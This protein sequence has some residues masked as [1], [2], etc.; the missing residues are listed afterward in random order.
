MVFGPSLGYLC[1]FQSVFFT[2]CLSF[3]YSFTSPP[4]AACCFFLFLLW[5]SSLDS[6]SPPK[7]FHRAGISYEVGFFLGGRGFPLSIS[8]CESLASCIDSLLPPLPITTRVFVSFSGYVLGM[9]MV[10]VCSLVCICEHQRSISGIFSL[11]LSTFL[12]QARSLTEARAYCFLHRLPGLCEWWLA[13]CVLGRLGVLYFSILTQTFSS[14]TFSFLI[15]HLWVMTPT[16]VTYQI[17]YKS[18]I[19]MTVPDSSEIT[20]T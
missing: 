7:S 6:A 1:D 12:Y 10:G 8:I 18:D 19:R 9:C 14:Q 4:N 13:G 15:L 3:I 11:L 20:V 2:F 5:L 17:P 16:G